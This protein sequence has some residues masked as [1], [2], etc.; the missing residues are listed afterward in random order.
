MVTMSN[1]FPLSAFLPSYQELFGEFTVQNDD[2]SRSVYSP[3]A[4]L[5]DLLELIGDSFEDSP[6]RERRPDLAGIALDGEHSYTELPYL[7]IVNE[8]LERQLDKDPDTALRGARFPLNLPFSLRSER[9]KQYLR[10][11]GIP[12]EELYRQFAVRVNADLVA[13]E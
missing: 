11:F 4:Y 1:G 13:R 9:R 2:E 5:A 3:A 12:P 10:R 7:D 6:L 8:V